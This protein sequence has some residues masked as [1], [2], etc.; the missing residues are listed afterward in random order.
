MKIAIGYPP[1]ESKKGIPFLGQNRQFQW[2]AQPWTAYPM[3][4]A[5]GATLLK[6]AGHEVVWLDG[7]AEGWTYQKWLEEIK[8]EK[9]DL[10]MLETKTPVVKRHWK[11][12]ND[13]KPPITDHRSLTILLTATRPPKARSRPLKC[14]GNLAHFGADGA[15]NQQR[16][17]CDRSPITV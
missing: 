15:D 5:Y 13:L 9:P 1:L 6:E 16:A 12:I 4:P 3:V 17:T 7:I 14:N 10:V 2:A 8:R 11:I